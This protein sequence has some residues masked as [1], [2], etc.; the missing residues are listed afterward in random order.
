MFTASDRASTKS[1]L[2]ELPDA[3]TMGSVSVGA[4]AE[5]RRDGRS[6][7]V[8]VCGSQELGPV[9]VHGR[10]DLVT[11]A[12]DKAKRQSQRTMDE[13]HGIVGR[14]VLCRAIVICGA[15]RIIKCPQ[16]NRNVSIYGLCCR[17]S[18]SA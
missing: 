9:L 11:K 4:G 12:L 3:K 13:T 18:L 10:F 2:V 17:K 14:L 5:K 1:D 16:T 6:N 15:P 7:T 8:V